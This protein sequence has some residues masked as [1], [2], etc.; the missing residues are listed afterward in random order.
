MAKRYSK[1]QVREIRKVIARIREDDPKASR[2][3]IAVALNEKG[4]RTT[5]GKEF[6]A[7]AV[8]NFLN[9]NGR[10]LMLRRN[11]KA[12]KARGGADTNGH[13][14]S[15]PKSDDVLALAEIVMASNVDEKKKKDLLRSIF[16]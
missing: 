3:V 10:G 5:I 16:A 1:E 9:N 2:D 14:P 13:A 15:R 11:K 4:H 6:D 8:G 12:S 7:G